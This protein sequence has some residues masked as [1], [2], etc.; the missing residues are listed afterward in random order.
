MVI[1]DTVDPDGGVDG[2]D[3]EVGG[4]VD[5]PNA[6]Q[7]NPPIH[8]KDTLAITLKRKE[9]HFQNLLNRSCDVGNRS[10]KF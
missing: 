6:G 8:G 3:G 10:F 4:E 5:S 9:K 7:D 2:T 1:Q